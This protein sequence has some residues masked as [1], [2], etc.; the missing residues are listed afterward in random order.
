MEPTL[1]DLG[2]SHVGYPAL[3]S[4]RESARSSA[5]RR[6]MAVA[7]SGG[8]GAGEFAPGCVR[9]P[10]G[11]RDVAPPS[12]LPRVEAPQEDEDDEHAP[13]T[14]AAI[15]FSVHSEQ[16]AARSRPGQGRDFAYPSRDGG[17]LAG[18]GLAPSLA[19]R[20]DGHVSDAATRISAA[21]DRRM[22]AGEP[23]RRLAPLTRLI[24]SATL[25]PVAL[26]EEK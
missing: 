17:A 15:A 18:T 7:S 3:E 9:N 2:G 8:S 21:S 22:R 5:A 25:S 19:A 23:E 12:V 4:N 1:A 16:R 24:N 14:A 20:G 13:C 26:S 11:V 10:Q 6:S